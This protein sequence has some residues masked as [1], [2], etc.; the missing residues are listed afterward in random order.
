[1]EV[2]RDDRDP[3][4]LWLVSKDDD[5]IP[6]YKFGYATY[7]KQLWGAILNIG[8]DVTCFVTAFDAATGTFSKPV[9]TKAPFTHAQPFGDYVYLTGRTFARLPKKLW[10][11]DQPGAKE[12]RPPKVE[13]ADTPAGRAAEALLLG[14]TEDARASLLK[15]GIAQDEV[16]K[17]LTQL[18]ALTKTAT[19]PAA[20]GP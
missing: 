8:G 1:M 11:L 4:R 7:P 20:A 9:R 13:C 18:D 6:P 2:I 14:K 16:R 10:A 12:D 17:M 5:V 15:A 19:K 3:D